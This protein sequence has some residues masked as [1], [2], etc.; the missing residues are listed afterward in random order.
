MIFDVDGWTA[1]YLVLA[2]LGIGALVVAAAAAA[3]A[4]RACTDPS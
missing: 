3:R 2:G 4:L 1:L